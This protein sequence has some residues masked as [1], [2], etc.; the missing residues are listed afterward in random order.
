MK[1]KSRETFGRKSVEGVLIPNWLGWKW[2]RYDLRRLFLREWEIKSSLRVGLVG[3]YQAG[4]YCW[5]ICSGIAEFIHSALNLLFHLCS[6]P[7]SGW[8]HQF[9]DLHFQPIHFIWGANSCTKLWFSFQICFLSSPPHSSSWHIL[10]SRCLYQ[11]PR[12]ILKAAPTD[13]LHSIF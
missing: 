10:P 1:S 2:E 13:P 5:C 7:W 6:S 4:V 9:T 3:S 11:K 8:S 12:G